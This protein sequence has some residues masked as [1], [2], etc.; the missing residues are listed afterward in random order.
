[1]TLSYDMTFASDTSMLGETC[2][3]IADTGTTSNTTPFLDG[4][5]NLKEASKE[6]AITD[7]YFTKIS[8]SKCSTIKGV[9]CDSNGKALD[10]VSI[11]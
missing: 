2:I 1:M 11:Y 7:A 9:I 4:L 6:D 3:F 8:G 10:A 5:N